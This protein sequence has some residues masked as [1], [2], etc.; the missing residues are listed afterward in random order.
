MEMAYSFLL[1]SDLDYLE[2][3]GA[4]VTYADQDT[5]LEQGS[6]RQAI[7]VVQD[8]T[9][10]VQREREDR[11][12]TITELGPGEVSAKCR[13]CAAAGRRHRSLRP[14]RPAWW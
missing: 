3:V 13:S 14:G 6:T 1:S 11:V 7:F 8:G 12:Y 2:E 5:I 10:K 9:V 4:T